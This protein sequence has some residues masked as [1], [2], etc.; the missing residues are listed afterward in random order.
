MHHS[1]PTSRR[2]RLFSRCAWATAAFRSAAGSRD[3]SYPAGGSF[4]EPPAAPAVVARVKSM[5][6]STQRILVRFIAILLERWLVSQQVSLR[7]GGS[8]NL[9]GK[10]S[11]K[12]AHDFIRRVRVVE[13]P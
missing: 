1:P 5:A 7:A 12:I 10:D 13:G 2:M 11:I 9:D 4:E 8:E 6:E 3:S